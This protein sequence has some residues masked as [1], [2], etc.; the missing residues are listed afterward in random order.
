MTNSANEDK[1][2]FLEAAA[3]APKAEPQAA[4]PQP[5]TPPAPQAQEAA[6]VQPQVVQPAQAEPPKV[7]AQGHTVPLPKYLEAFNEAREYK[8]RIADYEAKEKASQ[9][10]IQAPDPLLDPKGYGDFVRN[11]MR[12]EMQGEITQTRLN[13]SETMARQVHGDAAVEEA[14]Q[15]FEAK[16]QQA[17]WVVARVMN[18]QHPWN[19]MVAWHKQDKLLGEIGSDPD[20]WAR[21]RYATLNPAAQPAGA[22]PVPPA[23]PAPVAPPPS[24]SRAPAAGKPSEVPVGPGQA[25]A[26]VFG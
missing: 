3:P 11:Q 2:A 20:A 22:P 6:P 12:A 24:L 10:Q 1:L 13:I 18:S 26:G 16:A 17:P 15:A 7:D 19:E 14:K 23:P 4:S 25:F 21:A 9:A 5:E 8:K